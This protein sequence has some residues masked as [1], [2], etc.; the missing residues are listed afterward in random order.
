MK[1]ISRKVMVGDGLTNDELLLFLGECKNATEILSLYG[2]RYHVFRNVFNNYILDYSK[3]ASERKL[4]IRTSFFPDWSFVSQME[5]DL[6]K[7]EIERRTHETIIFLENLGE[8]YFLCSQ[9]LKNDLTI[10]KGVL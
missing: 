4:A 3:Y 1:N 5:A 6:N 9:S 8:T 10:N 2:Q 7:L